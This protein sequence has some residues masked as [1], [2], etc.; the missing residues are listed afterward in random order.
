MGFAGIASVEDLRKRGRELCVEYSSRVH[1]NNGFGF[2]VLFYTICL[3][4]Y[5]YRVYGLGYVYIYIYI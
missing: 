1:Y 3:L 2:L 5:T 4:D